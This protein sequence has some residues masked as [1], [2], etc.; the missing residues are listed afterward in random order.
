MWLGQLKVLLPASVDFQTLILII[1]P[2]NGQLAV[3]SNSNAD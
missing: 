1:A 2:E 3:Q